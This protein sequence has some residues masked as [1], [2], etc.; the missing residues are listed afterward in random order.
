MTVLEHIVHILLAEHV[1]GPIILQGSFNSEA[2]L[3]EFF[4]FHSFITVIDFKIFQSVGEG[5]ICGWF[6]VIS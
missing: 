4:I 3:L 1:F 6:P 5:H 2:L